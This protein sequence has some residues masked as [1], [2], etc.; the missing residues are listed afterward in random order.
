M[1]KVS[2]VRVYVKDDGTLDGMFAMVNSKA[3]ISVAWFTS[4]RLHITFRG[5]GNLIYVYNDVPAEVWNELV[6]ANSIGK[7]YNEIV[8]DKFTYSV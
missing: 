4:G 8:K 5:N 2:T 3:L 1:D 6:N 7:K